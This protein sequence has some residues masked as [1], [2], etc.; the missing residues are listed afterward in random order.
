MLQSSK[1]NKKSLPKTPRLFSGSI[2][3]THSMHA[4]LHFWNDF[5]N[6]FHA[7]VPAFLARFSQ[8]IPCTHPC[9]SGSIF[10]THSMYASLH[11]WL[12]FCNT[13]HAR[14]PAFLARFSQHIPCS[15]PRVIVRTFS[16]LRALPVAIHAKRVLEKAVYL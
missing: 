8:H 9:I 6:I 4:S 13:F 11:F 1:K 14:I 7:R 16:R 2:F 3:A 5:R 15:R 12:D 10:A